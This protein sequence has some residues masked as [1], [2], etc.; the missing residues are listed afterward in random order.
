MTTT[1]KNGA[2]YSD[3]GP[4][5]GCRTRYFRDSAYG[6]VEWMFAVDYASGNRRWYGFGMNPNNSIAKMT[7]E[8]F[9]LSPLV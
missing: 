8:G 4:A 9:T 6:G 1:S 5:R 3:D 7:V 2:I